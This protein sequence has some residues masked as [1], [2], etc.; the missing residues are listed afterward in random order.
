RE[1]T[2]GQWRDRATS[3]RGLLARAAIA[4]R[5]VEDEP[6]ESLQQLIVGQGLAGLA[7][8]RRLHVAKQRHGRF[9]DLE[10]KLVLLR[11]IR[12]RWIV[13]PIAGRALGDH[14]LALPH[15][16]PRGRIAP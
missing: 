7:R 10:A 8:Q 13:R 1:L 15:R 2:D 9:A 5:P 16:P 3:D 4:L 14:R 12:G 11:W 6:R